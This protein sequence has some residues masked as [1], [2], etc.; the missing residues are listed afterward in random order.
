[1]KI[2]GFPNVSIKYSNGLLGVLPES[3][4]GLLAMVFTDCDK[5]M[6]TELGLESQ[7]EYLLYGV[8][9]LEKEYL[10]SHDRIKEAVTDF[11]AVAAEGTP[12]Y[13][14]L[15]TSDVKSFCSG[16]ITPLVEKLHGNIR[17]IIIETTATEEDSTGIAKDIID[18]IPTAHDA[19]MTCAESKN[20]PI[21]VIFTAQLIAT[22]ADLVDLK[23]KNYNRCGVCIGKHE[24]SMYPITGLIAGRIASV[25]IQRNI[26]AVRDGRLPAEDLHLGPDMLIDDNMDDVRTAHTKGYIVP[27]IYT[28]RSGYY[29]SDDMMAIDQT[30]DYAH[31]TNRRVIDKA[32]RIVYDTLLDY[33]M[34]EVEVNDDGTMQQ[35]VIK[36]WQAAVESAIDQQMTA[37][38]ELSAV[39]GSGCRCII[40]PSQNVLATSQINVVLKVRPYG[41]AREIVC[42]LGFLTNNA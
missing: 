25:P 41:Y 28:G 14:V 23:A 12:V 37:R 3:A 1:M 27:R 24:N 34:G 42:E 35:P 26:G 29:F 11:Y 15:T 10:S 5:G 2:M 6:M 30:D 18:S 8:D 38:G 9:S 22:V 33:L 20:A 21:F 39:D 36:S 16:G 7:G 31:L 17:G 40:D 19:A 32:A 13:V 4:D